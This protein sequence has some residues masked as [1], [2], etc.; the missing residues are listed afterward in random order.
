MC[1]F[2]PLF[3]YFRLLDGGQVEQN[4]RMTML[5]SHILGVD[6]VTAISSGVF[7]CIFV[8]YKQRNNKQIF[9]L[10]GHTDDGSTTY[11]L[12]LWWPV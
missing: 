7:P 5:Q 1:H 2:R 10:N 12:R 6:T 3:H 4:V 9:P 11:N 8:L